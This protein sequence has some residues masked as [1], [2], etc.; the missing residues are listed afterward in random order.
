MDTRH[1]LNR[2]WHAPYNI[3]LNQTELFPISLEV[4]RP[5]VG[6]LPLLTPSARANWRRT[7]IFF[8]EPFE[9][10]SQVMGGSVM[11]RA[12]HT[13]AT[14]EVTMDSFATL[15][16]FAVAIAGFS[17]IAIAIQN[18]GTSFDGLVAFRNQNLL[19]HA[20]GAAFGSI[21]PHAV[22]HLGVTG[23]SVWFWSSLLLGGIC[24]A[25]HWN[26]GASRRSLSEEE[27]SRLSQTMMRIAGGGNALVILAQLGN[28]L[29][30]FGPSSSAAVYLGIVWLL[31]LAS[32]QFLFLLSRPTSPTDA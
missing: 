24:C 11:R 7:L 29:G 18:R 16:E 9:R 2:I 27:D 3:H 6:N 12:T 1:I 28:S 13:G 8:G 31:M 20:L 26:F 19:L 17:G 32:I 22:T 23:H 15:T 4:R 10:I 5:D 14:R 25:T 21:C 30:A